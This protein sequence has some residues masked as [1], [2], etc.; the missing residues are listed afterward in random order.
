MGLLDWFQSR[1]K[2]ESDKYVYASIKN[3]NVIND[4]GGT[5]SDQPF[6][7]G[8]HYFRLWLVEMF[9]ENDREWFTSWHP[10]VHAGI[11]FKFGNSEEVITRVAGASLL[12]DLSTD[13]LDR[14]IGLNY[15]MTP[16]VPFNGGT[17]S[18]SAGLLAIAGKNDVKSFLKVLGDFS[19]LLMVPQLSAAL[20]IATPLANGLSE[21]V[22][23]TTNNLMLGL[24]Q[25]WSSGTGGGASLRAGYVAVVLAKDD[26]IDRDRLWVID[27]RLRYGVASGD[28]KPLTG[29]NYMLFRL[30]R[31]DERDDWDSLT[32]IRDPYN[33]AIEMLQAGNTEQADA[34]IRAAK[35]AAFLAPELTQ[36]VD[37][38][39]VVKQIQQRYEE[40]KDDLG[41]G[42]FRAA[43]ETSFSDV[44]QGAISVTEAKAL[45]SLLPEEV[46][47]EGLAKP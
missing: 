6:A 15:P 43:A 36:N 16:L 2:S 3:S 34:F 31:R 22:G 19:N 45:G 27:G 20:T 37:R 1:W 10:A 40:A 46:G 11:S 29:F 17:V 42:A 25:T 39:R 28:A 9:L 33:K 21:L 7:A 12:P 4:Q 18:L 44:M 35:A 5:P 13:N 14:V 38:R 32:A 30:E 24:Q 8:D 23:A 41:A 47:L 26:E